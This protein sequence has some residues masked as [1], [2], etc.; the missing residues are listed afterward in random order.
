LLTSYTIV[1]R[2]RK[3]KGRRPEGKGRSG[4]A[5]MPATLFRPCLASRP[6]E[7]SRKNLTAGCHEPTPTSCEAWAITKV[8]TFCE[9]QCEHSMFVSISPRVRRTAR[10]F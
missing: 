8:F 3:E 7:P 4:G 6:K 2:S 9:P 10:I 5:V 1:E